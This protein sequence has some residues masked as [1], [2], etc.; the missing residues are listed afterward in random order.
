[1]LSLGQSLR[2]ISSV[3]YEH[4]HTFIEQSTYKYISL[5]LFVGNHVETVISVSV[6]P[7]SVLSVYSCIMHI[8]AVSS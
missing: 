7:F 3:N 2:L 5:K 1:M 8:F 6:L 4:P